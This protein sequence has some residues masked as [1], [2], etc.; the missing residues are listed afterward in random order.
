[1][2]QNKPFTKGQEK[3]GSIVINVMSALNTW[4]FR[5]S[6]GKLG[7]RFPGGA[8]VLLLTTIGRKSG[9]RRTAPLL[10]LKDGEDYVIVASK[11]GMSHHPAWYLNLR[12]N[13]QVE[14]EVGRDK[15][16]MTARTASADEKKRL[17]PDLVAMYPSYDQ[18][19]ART[20][21]EIPVIVL[22]PA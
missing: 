1:M 14:I 12:D 17:W 9:A 10:Y 2:P 15:R 13:P 6:G 7:A 22:S 20:D 3:V 11:G 16:R 4:A 5:M 18:Y 19:Q 21:R 8:P